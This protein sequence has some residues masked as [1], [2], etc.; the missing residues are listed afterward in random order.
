M[1]YWNKLSHN[2]IRFPADFDKIRVT[3]KSKG[4][5]YKIS[6]EAEEYAVLFVCHA[7]RHKIDSVFKQNFWNDFKKMLTKSMHNMKFEDIEFVVDD[8]GSICKTYSEITAI[9][10]GQPC[11]AKIDGRVEKMATCSVERPGLFIGR[12]DNPKRGKIKH[13]I[14]PEEVTI[15]IEKGKIPVAPKGHHWKEVVHEK[16]AFWL[17]KWMDPVTKKTKYVWLSSD[18]KI[19]N[20]N[21]REKFELARKLG[22]GI[23]K[24]QNETS[25]L[26]ASSDDRDKQTGIIMFLL[27]KL[28][29][30]IGGENN[31]DRVTG[32][33]TLHKQHVTFDKK[34]NIIKFDFLG[35]DSIRY[36]KSLKVPSNIFNI[37]LNCHNSAGDVLFPKTSSA[38]VNSTITNLLGNGMTAKVFRTFHLSKIYESKLKEFEKSETDMKIAVRKAAESAA[39]F[40]NHQKMDKKTGKYILERGTVINN[41]IDPRITASFVKRH[42]LAFDKIYTPTQKSKF[43]WAESAQ[44]FKF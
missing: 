4:K 38:E 32:L 25:K 19:K 20:Q 12:G 26:I 14:T 2:G 23:H 17:A 13:R 34:T 24:F 16:N 21:D 9:P 33:T 29:I 18:S 6:K 28:A 30:R 15:N 39:E 3:V 40:S 35:K 10:K 41:Y 42:G 11:T 27:D 22:K 31:N 5:T 1:S 8:K 36:N 44:N 7:S 37:I 43:K